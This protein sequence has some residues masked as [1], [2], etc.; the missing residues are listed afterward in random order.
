MALEGEMRIARGDVLL[1][2]ERQQAN[3]FHILMSN[4]HRDKAGIHD[5][6]S[7][8]EDA[9]APQLFVLVLP[10]AT[11]GQKLPFHRMPLLARHH[12]APFSPRGP[13]LSG[14]HVRGYP[15]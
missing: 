15:V 3:P 2:V 11:S 4:E 8:Q 7:N 10:D 6:V 1:L 13:T 12:L 5:G 14:R 9:Q